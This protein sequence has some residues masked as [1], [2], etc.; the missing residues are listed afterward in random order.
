MVR[1]VIAVIVSLVVA[2]LIIMSIQMINFVLFPIPDSIDQNNMEQMKEYVQGLPSL[3]YFVVIISYFV[4][5]LIAAL[6][7][8]KIADSHFRKIAIGIGVFLTLMGIINLIRIP[9][10]LWFS[11]VTV[12]LYV[13]AAL[14]GYRLSGKQ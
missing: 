10:P 4:G 1:N 5:A 11:I 6:V 14:L 12:L 9:H 3:A 7:A 8:C 13:P 2:F